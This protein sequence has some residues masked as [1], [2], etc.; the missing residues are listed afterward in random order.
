[1][2][3][4]DILTRDVV[5]VKPDTTLDEVARILTDKKISGLPVVN[6][7]GNLVGIISEGDLL[8]KD[9]KVEFP[10]YIN[11]LGGII[12]LDSFHDYLEELKKV[13]AQEVE[14]LMQKDVV[15]ISPEAS[16]EDMATLMVVNNI[17]RLPVVED[18]KL[19]GIVTRA[20]II[21]SWVA[22]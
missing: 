9:S 18:G 6:D 21:K 1:M 22:K 3:A 13:V 20:D 17:N 2:K 14:Q 11:I 4:K 10:S 5:T 19:V 15:S 8:R 16:V 12:Y 7:I